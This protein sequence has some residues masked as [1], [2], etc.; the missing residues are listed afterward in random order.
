[1]VVFNQGDVLDDEFDD[2]ERAREFNAL[3]E[4]YPN[5]DGSLENYKEFVAHVPKIEHWSI[6]IKVL[7]H[8]AT[9]QL[10]E[11]GF[12]FRKRNFLHK[13]IRLH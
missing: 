12:T 9:V 4:G 5:V 13:V 7:Q 11:L 10:K 6:V 8:Q 3:Y 2:C 1:M